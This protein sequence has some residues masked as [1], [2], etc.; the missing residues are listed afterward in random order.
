MPVARSRTV[1]V[2]ATP[3][4]AAAHLVVQRNLGADSLHAWLQQTLPDGWTVTR[5]G[6][7]KGYRVLQVVA[8]T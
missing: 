2:T 7:A 5:F 1:L 3:P 4:G 8:P 6:S